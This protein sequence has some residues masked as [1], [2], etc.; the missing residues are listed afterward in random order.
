MATRTRSVAALAAAAAFAVPILVSL[1][2]TVRPTRRVSIGVEERAAGFAAE[3][4]G[5]WAV[6]PDGTFYLLRI[7]LRTTDPGRLL[8]HEE[9]GLE[10]LPYAGALELADADVSFDGTGCAYRTKPGFTLPPDGLLTVQRR[11]GCSRMEGT[12][13][14]RML[15]TLRLRRE[16]RA[17]IRVAVRPEEPPGA[18][19]VSAFGIEHPPGVLPGARHAGRS[20]RST[21][22]QPP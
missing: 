2:T 11:P 17:A 6:E 1:G 5:R 22:R 16:G 19:V 10:I 15:L 20:R 7:G 3:L 4:R 13:D 8:A 21:G 18:V 14:G 9:I 12:P